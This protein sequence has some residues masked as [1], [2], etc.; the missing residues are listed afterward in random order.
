[1]SD[2]L[3]LLQEKRNKIEAA[4]GEKR[5]EK[6]HKI[7]KLTARERLNLLFD[8]GSFVELDAFVKHRCTNF[9]MEKMDAPADGVVTGYGQVDGRIV[10]A[11][12][13]D[14][15]VVGGSLGEMHAAKIC[16]VLDNALKV[17]APVVGLNDSGGA[18][19]QEGIDALAGYGDIFFRNTMASGVIPQITAIMG[20]CAGGAVY[21]PALNDFI[22]MVDKTSQMFITGP[23]VIKTVTGEEVS[24]EALGG[25]MTHNQT[26]GVAQYIAS[27][28]EECILQIRRLL[29]FLPSNNMETAPV[30]DTANDINKRIDALNTIIPPNPNKPYDMKDIIEALVDAGDFLEYQPYFAKNILTGFARLG[31]KSVGIIANQ[32]KVLAGCM[33]L[34]TGD[35][36]ARFIRTCDAFNIPILTLVDTPGFLPGTTQ[37]YGGIIRHGAK[38][39]YAYSEA[40]VP[41]VTLIVRKAYGG[42]YIAMSSKHL[43]SDMVLAWPSA[44]IAVMGPQGAANIIFRK[45]IADADNPAAVRQQKVDAYTAEFAT[46]YKAAERGYV[47]D[48]IEPAQTRPRLIAAFDM[49]AGK[50][51]DRP[52]KK[53]GNIPL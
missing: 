38:I 12:A 5:V 17:G 2:K 13:Q 30:Y 41:L 4:G 52:A 19:I 7:G 35:K 29:S 1:M 47:D 25:A 50:R 48:V 33:D 3:N 26:S 34:N 46:P 28:D 51:E 6:Q 24:A 53:H 27:T 40:T 21:S 23:Q 16:K 14:F 10:Y 22:F 15:T 11:F 32:P 31:G 8:E 39:L 18:R 45:D 20:P 37:E 9:G 44:E 36:T 43:G 42:A 49:L